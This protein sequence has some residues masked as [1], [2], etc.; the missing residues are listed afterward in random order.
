MQEPGGE[1]DVRGQDDSAYFHHG[2]VELAD[3]LPAAP[4]NVLVYDLDAT[5]PEVV[6]TGH[7]LDDDSA[8]LL[9][10]FELGFLDEL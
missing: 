1:V 4:V 6:P 8:A 10:V 3:C 2:D 5:S 7:M 9:F